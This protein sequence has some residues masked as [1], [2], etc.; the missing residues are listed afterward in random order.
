MNKNDKGSLVPKLRFPEFINR[1]N[2]A[3]VEISKNLKESRI[4][5]SDGEIAKKLTVK[6]WGRGVFEKKEI[7]RGSKSTQYY[8]RKAGQF[9][10]S[11]LDFLNQAFGII[12]RHLEGYESTVDLPC[13]DVNDE[14]DVRFLL[15]YVKR[16]SFYKNFGEIADGGRKAKRIQVETFLGF[17]IYL[18]ELT[19][20][21]KIADCLSSL[22]ELI[23]AEGK[24][25]EELKS[26]KKGLMQKLFP[27]EGKSV[28][29]WRFP[30]FRDSGE[31]CNNELAGVGKIITGK[32]PPTA[33]KSLWDGKIQFVTP[34]DITESK[35]QIVTER[36]VIESPKIKVLPAG[37]IL[38]TCIASVGKMAISV[39]P[40]ITNQQ[41]NAIVPFETFCN[42]Y[43]YYALLERSVSIKATL[44]N[45]TLPIINKTEFSK[46]SIA[47]PL[48]LDEQQKI[49]DCLSSIDQ[50][51]SEQ[52]R[53]VEKLEEH[54]K[55]LT[56]GLF[57][58]FEEVC[59]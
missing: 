59:K 11:K 54:K 44:A 12:P 51:I 8:R 31:W 21:Q 56:Q 13:F 22:D 32:T 38:F 15:E 17:L 40:C 19:E 23:A 35:Y 33:D 37:S 46:I 9:I 50:L 3:Q 47:V 41:I 25:L 24:K 45:S 28:P 57:P 30:E 16:E 58:S 10:Y 42:E 26:H 55:G 14:L 2:W 43:I 52:S 20:Q 36:T 18:P 4:K 53:K 48:L 27:A 29:E 1:E 6:L 7:L 39:F 49:A 5:G 34:T